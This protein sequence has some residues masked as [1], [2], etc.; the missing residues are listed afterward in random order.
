MAQQNRLHALYEVTT[1]QTLSEEERFQAA[2]EV[3]AAFLDMQ[4]GTVSH[5]NG[6]V[7]TLLYGYDFEVSLETGLVVPLA[8]SLDSLILEAQDLV[9]IEN[10]SESEYADNL[11]ADQPVEALIGVPV[12]VNGDLFGS[13][14]F[15]DRYPRP[16]EFEQED[17][18]IVRMLGQ[19]MG[20][21]LECL[22]QAHVLRE[23]EMRYDI[24]FEGSVEGV[25][26]I[27]DG[28]IADANPAFQKMT[29]FSRQDIVGS[30]LSDFITREWRDYVARNIGERL[31]SPIEAVGL[32]SDGSGYPL[33]IQG[34]SIARKG[35]PILMVTVRDLSDRD[36]AEVAEREQQVLADVLRDSAA[37]LSS[38]LNL[39]DVLDNILNNIGQVVP[40][41]AAS[42]ML[43]EG[44][45]ARIVRTRGYSK[46]GGKQ[47]AS[48]VNS[49]EFNLQDSSNLREIV[50][51]SQPVIISDVLDYSDW[52]VVDATAWIR[53]Y[54]GMPILSDGEVIGLLNLD[55]AAPNFFT[56]AHA[57]RLKVFADQAAA[58][59]R[60]A[61]LYAKSQQRNQQLALLNRIT[62]ISAAVLE[63][64]DLLQAL[65]D[66]V[67][68]LIGGDGAFI[69]LWDEESQEP[70]LGAA[71]GSFDAAY[72]KLFP[73]QPGEI[74][75]TESAIREGRPLVIDDIMDSPYISP[76]LA[77]QLPIESA[78]VIPLM[79][80]E[81]D[82]G[83]LVVV[84][85]SSHPF[86]SE[87]I[88]WIVQAAELISLAISKA[89]VYA[90]LES[91]NRELDAFSHTVAHDLKSPLAT[92]IGALDLLREL[93][94]NNLTAE[95]QEML[96]VAER[97]T[98]RMVGIIESLLLLA[99]LQSAQ[100][101][102]GP[103]EMLPVIE[104]SVDRLRNDINGRGV[105]LEID[106][107]LPDVMGYDPWLEE[108]FSNLI[109]N[110]VKYI[111][112]QNEDPQI[113][114]RAVRKDGHVRYEVAD[115][116]LGI[117]EADQDRL[118]EM[119]TRF[120]VSANKGF[121][122]GLSIVQ[123]IVHKLNGQ[124]GVISAPGEGS[125][126]WFTLPAVD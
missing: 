24:L 78:L 50:T 83:A 98:S 108:V 92:A 11:F 1:S 53:S 74:T 49:L 30:H 86:D 54:A 27:E 55:S 116:G 121:G 17:Q 123:R 65:S 46:H 16:A 112:D 57:E 80:N 96:K 41:D 52:Q 25:L 13:L 56:A 32:R 84:F 34:K 124:I 120:H 9:A 28:V 38:T 111:G 19:W 31:E 81:R 12:W 106:P 47:A 42:I 100:K 45:I 103:V 97:S 125:T 109:S 117:E 21:S 35:L 40:H 61:H 107:N 67:A 4:R 101:T 115:N 66:S 20:I 110:A 36:R 3:T 99:Q 10:L 58:A 37:T 62:R 23:S 26:F 119:F 94:I 69:T 68:M 90:E 114:I 59:I 6:T 33:Q 95:G 51:T 8:N 73:T 2:L 7:S 29:G 82:L 105:K 91:R 85:N 122:L 88:A 71:C 60:N 113:M 76:R 77:V 89:E 75:L 70:V 44:D 5:V 14:S 126:F 64:N 104:K 22:L 48:V 15:T 118:F 39:D 43:L 79:A 63:M 93:E 18:D 102:I 87:E 72:Q